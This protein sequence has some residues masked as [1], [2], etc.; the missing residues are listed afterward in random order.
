MKHAKEPW[1]LNIVQIDK[2]LLLG[3]LHE[4]VISGDEVVCVCF[5]SQENARRIIACVNACVGMDDEK[6]YDHNVRKTF[7]ESM[8]I[9]AKYFVIKGEQDKLVAT[10]KDCNRFI[11]ADSNSA[12]SMKLAISNVIAEVEH[13]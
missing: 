12:N 5:E 13:E 1:E 7:L 8:N 10:L 9:V 6:L 11:A 3:S 4:A 2:E